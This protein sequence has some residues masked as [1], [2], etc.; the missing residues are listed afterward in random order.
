VLIP[1]PAWPGGKPF[2]FTIVDDTDRSTLEN[3][4]PVYDLLVDLGFRTTKT[5]FPLEPR[6]KKAYPYGSLQDPRYREWILDLQQQGFEIA[7]HG[8]SDETSSRER[9]EQGLRLFSDVV[10]AGP[11]MHVNHVGQDDNIYWYADRLVGPPRWIYQAAVRWKKRRTVSLGHDGRSPNF[12]GDIVQ[13]RID[14][15]R[16]FTFSEINTLKMDPWMPYHSDAHP[17]VKFWYSASQGTDCRRFKELVAERAQDRLASEGGCCILYTHFG[18]GYVK[19]G[20]LDA[21]FARLMK[22]L[23]AL[24][25]YV[26]PASALLDVLRTR[27]GWKGR[28]GAMDLQRLQVRWL[29]EKLRIGTT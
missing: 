1:A 5:V 2:G 26:A 24:G 22:R 7:M 4:K 21:D 23:A 13:A 8:V 3:T 16:N 6:T 18:F 11:R 17:Y 9:I 25:G 27:P 28:I 19:D 12:W 15:V 20:K 10:G 29:L 14:Y